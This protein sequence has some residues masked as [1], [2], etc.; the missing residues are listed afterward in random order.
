MAIGGSARV[1][2]PAPAAGSA[3]SATSSAPRASWSTSTGEVSTVSS[4]ASAG[5]AGTQAAHA[6]HQPRVQHR[7]DRADAQ[8][9]RPRRAT[10]ELGL[11]LALQ[12][13]QLLGVDE[14]APP[15]AR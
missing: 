10:A 1:R 15:G 14:E 12:V 6:F 11:D 3:A 7:F 5:C 13:E 8:H 9:H 4:S 2:T